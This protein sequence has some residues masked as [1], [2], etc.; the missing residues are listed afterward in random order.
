VEQELI[1]RL[2]TLRFA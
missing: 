1:A 2:G